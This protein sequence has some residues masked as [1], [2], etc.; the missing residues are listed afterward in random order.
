MICKGVAYWGR[1]DDARILTVRQQHLFALNPKTGAPIKG[2]GDD[3]K[4]DLSTEEFRIEAGLRALARLLQ[5]PR[6]NPGQLVK[7]CSATTGRAT[8]RRL[9][10][11]GGCPNPP[12]QLSVRK[13]WRKSP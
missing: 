3:G 9:T 4:V 13:H 5:C 11:G 6:S 8:S 10:L 2:F 7:T 12:G 1:G